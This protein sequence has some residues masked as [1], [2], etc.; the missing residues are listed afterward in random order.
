MPLKRFLFFCTLL[1]AADSPFGETGIIVSQNQEPVPFAAIVNLRS[2]TWSISNERGIFWIPNGTTKGD[3][4]QIN[5]IGLQAISLVYSCGWLSVIMEN[6]PIHFPEISVRNNAPKHFEIPVTGTTRTELMSGLPGAILRSYGGSAGIAQAAMEG[7][8]TA[9]V[10]AIFNGIDLT[11]PQNG[12]TDLSQIPKQFLGFGM[13]A[14]NNHLEF[15]SGSTDGV[16]QINPWS[17][18]TGIELQRGQDGSMSYSANLNVDSERS[19]ARITLGKN[20]DPGTHPVFYKSESI[21]R[22]NQGFNQIFS[23][24]QGELR[25]RK[26]ITKGSFWHSTQDRGISGLIWS[27]NSEAFRKDT[28]SLFSGSVIRLMP[29]GYL[30][31][32]LSYRKSGENYVNPTLSID[33]DHVS[34]V[35]STDISGFIVPSTLSVFR[36]HSGFAR[37]LVNS[38]DAG[39]HLRN[40]FFIAPSLSMAQ[41]LG[42]NLSTAL[43]FDHYSDFGSA[44][45]YA[46]NVRRELS[47]YFSIEGSAKSSFRAPTFNDLYWNPGGNPELES[48]QSTSS[49]ISAQLT[50]E[51]S[52][53][54]LFYKKS[55]STNLIVWRSTGDFWQPEN[56][57]RTKRTILGINGQFLISDRL[58]FHTSLLNIQST[59]QITDQ[60]LRYS[61]NWIGSFRSQFQ[62]WNWTSSFSLH[63]TGEQIVM[64]DYPEDLTLDP[65]G[66]SNFTVEAPPIFNDQLRLN[67]SVSNLFNQEIMTIYGYPE[68]SRT[69]RAKISYKLNKK[70]N[71]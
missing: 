7:G 41:L 3:S 43:R 19:V 29:H 27:P 36:F 61:P 1:Y 63:F 39:N 60:R 28:L 65:T 55:N 4:L 8:R 25:N 2:G 52:N 54:E 15:G 59:N 24:I 35:F 22:T 45:T 6:D 10:K 49:K 44:L 32:S 17:H 71:K 21:E 51:K 13:L 30:K 46:G 67:V 11:S 58:S 66:I 70:V 62:M 42:I 50:F 37:E 20:T 23:G 18:P 12:L 16:L 40:R 31:S 34:E 14:Q 26:W 68:P 56:V 69:F 64:Y 57:D 9:D 47:Q 33:S 53:L 38:T 48:E 5:R